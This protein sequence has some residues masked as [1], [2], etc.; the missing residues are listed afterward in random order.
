MT[1]SCHLYEDNS[2]IFTS[3]VD[4]CCSLPDTVSNSGTQVWSNSCQMPMGILTSFHS[5]IKTASYL[6]PLLECIK[7]CLLYNY[8]TFPTNFFH[9]YCALTHICILLWLSIGGV[10]EYLLLSGSY[11]GIPMESCPLSSWSYS[12][13]I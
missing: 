5:I 7:L 11:K 1:T 10:F 2:A 3:S 9:C 6:S 8:I 12:Y 4:Q 13:Y